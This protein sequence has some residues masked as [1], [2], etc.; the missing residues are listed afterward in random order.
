VR[1]VGAL[2][3]DVPV[4]EAVEDAALGDDRLELAVGLRLVGLGSRI[5]TV[6]RDVPCL[7]SVFGPGPAATASVAAVAAMAS[8]SVSSTPRRLIVLMEPPQQAETARRPFRASDEP[9]VSLSARSQS[10]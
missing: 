9:V 2:G 8:A 1:A 6:P 3:V 10:R 7:L 4:E 5:R